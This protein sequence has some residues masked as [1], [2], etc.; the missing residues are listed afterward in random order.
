MPSA[1]CSSLRAA[2]APMSIA[3]SNVRPGYF[4]RAM[5]A[6]ER[7]TAALTPGPRALARI[8]HRV[9]GRPDVEPSGV[10]CDA[11]TDD[12][13]IGFDGTAIGQPYALDPLVPVETVDADTEPQIDTVVAMYGAAQGAHLVAQHPPEGHRQR[14]DHRDIEPA[15]AGRRDTPRR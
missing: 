10:G 9:D 2:C 6:T 12:H 1:L 11:D 5:W 8:R 7:I 13:D 14:L 4:F 15:F 3:W